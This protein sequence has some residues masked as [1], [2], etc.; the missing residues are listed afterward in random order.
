M[1]AIDRAIRVCVGAAFVIG[2]G[3]PALAQ[4]ELVPQGSTWSYL[5][6]GVFPGAA[7]K[8]PGFDDSGWDS[9]PAQLGYGDGDEA[10]VVGYG[11]N[12][13]AKFTTTWFRTE[14]V[15]A[16]PGTIPLLQLGVLRDDGVVVYLNSAEVFRSNIPGGTILPTT[17]ASTAIGGAAEDTFHEAFAD[18]DL[19]VAGTNTL[20]AEIHQ[21]NGTSS[22]IS[23][24]LWLRGHDGT[25]GLVRGPY[26]QT[27]RS[28][29]VVVRWG[30]DLPSQS[31][32]HYGDAPGNLTQMVSDATSLTDHELEITGLAP[33]TTYF[34]S[35]GTPGGAIAGDD[36]DHFFATTPPV[37]ADVPL[38]A[39]VLGDSGTANAD[40]AA[41]RDAYL[42]WVAG[43]GG[44][45]ADMVM[46]LGDNAY[47]DGTDPEYQAA[48]F[49]MYPTV[50]RNT[51]LWPTLG[52][53]DGH[54]AD[55]ATESGPYYDIFTLPRGAE[56]GGLASG[57]EAY[58]SF[59]VANVHFVCLD[60]YETDRSTSGDMLTWLDADLV[61]TGQDWL[62]AFFHHPPYSRGSHNS[63]TETELIEMRQFALPILESAGVDLVLCGHSHSYERSYL[64]DG[65][66]G[67]LGTFDTQTML[68]DGGDGSEAGDGAYEKVHPGIW[69][70]SGAVYAVAGSSGKTSGGP[71]DHPVMLVNLNTLGSMVIDVDGTRLDA[72]FITSTGQVA[73][74][75]TILK[76]TS[77]VADLDAD[78]DTDVFDFGLFALWFGSSVAPGTNGD[79]D[80]D[81]DVDVFDF[82]AFAADFGCGV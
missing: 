26:L 20:A 5:D 29:G 9:G 60:S 46:M 33:G 28:E 2:A 49:D 1:R 54:S 62:I 31:V 14:F 44:R 16:D 71:L 56:A 63:D 51:V 40:A 47:N 24:D 10:T 36:A 70:H 61:S 74:E 4:P 77:C 68:V 32:V 23:L 34:Y 80:D 39:W 11:S 48:V 67:L 27:L 18:A 72:R 22:D 58:Y 52:N 8:D 25:V 82:G 78:F 43:T 73:D 3:A 79:L 41:V 30:T 13:S 65:H 12:S 57:T 42:G 35:V 59:D 75:F 69:T 50:L 7:W 6:T 76:P 53:H 66:Y 21:A 15:V 38:R 64:I 55:S 37:G 19:L 17:P 45:D 81:G